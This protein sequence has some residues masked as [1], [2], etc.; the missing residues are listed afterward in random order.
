M[1]LLCVFEQFAYWE[2]FGAFHAG[3]KSRA[4]TDMFSKLANCCLQ[5][6]QL[7]INSMPA[8]EGTCT[9][10][11]CHMQCVTF[12]RLPICKNVGLPQSLLSNEGVARSQNE[13]V[14]GVGSVAVPNTNM[15]L[16]WNW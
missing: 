6:E 5:S 1:L 7:A 10:S 8:C 12:K 9:S 13:G 14:H 16:V 4:R 15:A 11:E 2:G 3:D